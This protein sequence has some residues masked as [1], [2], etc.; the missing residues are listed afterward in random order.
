MEV[1]EAE[2]KALR[3]LRFVDA[4]DREVAAAGAAAPVVGAA[5]PDAAGA[6]A[7]APDAGA[8]APDAAGAG[9]TDL[10]SPTSP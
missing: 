6:G 1:V 5:A 9:A 7:A 4:V 2:I 3:F 8:A 10:P